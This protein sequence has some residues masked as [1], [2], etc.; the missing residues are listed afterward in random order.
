M[1]LGVPLD[2]GTIEYQLIV[3]KSKTLFSY[4]Y[5]MHIIKYLLEIYSLWLEYKEKN[6]HMYM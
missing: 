3:G 6:T 2:F 4:F 5:A 1:K